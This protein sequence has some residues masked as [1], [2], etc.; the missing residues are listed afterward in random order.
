MKKIKIKICNYDEK[1][2][3]SYGY[4]F[5]NILKKYYVVEISEDPDYLFYNEST[6]DHLKYN[7]VK[8]F[9]TGE[10]IHPNF[11]FCDYALGFDYLSFG[12]RYY[13]LPIYLV[14]TYYQEKELNQAENIDFTKPRPLTKQDL[15]NKTEFCS[16]VY[17]NYLADSARK[18]FFDKLSE[19]KKV[20]AGGRYLNNIG[21]RV[22]NKLEFEAKHKFS[23]AFE[24]S[25]NAGYTTEKIVTALTARTIPIYWGNPEIAREFNGDCFINCHQ[26]DNFGQVIERIKEIDANDDLY[27]SMINQPVLAKNYNPEEIKNGLETFLR[28]II[29][30]PLNRARRVKINH[31]RK[32]E[33]EK[34]E[35]IAFKYTERQAKIKKMVAKLYKP[36]KKIKILENL[37]YRYFKSKYNQ[38]S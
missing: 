19:Y 23:I 2:K 22:D 34:R 13:H 38:K 3:C 28:N 6:D 15:A 18:D 14:A 8:I 29:D 21:G 7:C 31:Q 30:Q 5:V 36:L 33:L 25:S 20:N 9:Y 12:D 10:N 11:N 27:L 4:F 35:G 1:D 16:F 17:S 37:K 26:Y 32:I 24:N